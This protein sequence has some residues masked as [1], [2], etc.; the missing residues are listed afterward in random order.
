VTPLW[1]TAGWGYLR[2][3]EGTAQPWPSYGHQALRSWTARVRQA[4]PGTADVYVYFN[5]D[6]GGAAVVNSAVFAALAG[7]AGPDRDPDVP[8]GRRAAHP[9]GPNLVTG[10]VARPY[11]GHVTRAHFQPAQGV[12]IIRAGL[13]TS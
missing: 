9:G 13:F 11:T 7:K 10:H 5:N 3:H 2:F 12:M 6:P 8:G 4:W 1:R